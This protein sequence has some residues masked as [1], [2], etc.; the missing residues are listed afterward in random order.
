MAELAAMAETA[1]MRCT[2]KS[3]AARGGQSTAFL[4]QPVATLIFEIQRQGLLRQSK[5]WREQHEGQ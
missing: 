3:Q 4:M 5:G 1:A 2:W